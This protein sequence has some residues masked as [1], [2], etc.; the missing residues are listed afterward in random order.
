[1]KIDPAIMIFVFLIGSATSRRMH[2]LSDE[3]IDYINSEQTL[4]RAGRNFPRNTPLSYLK[5]LSGTIKEDTRYGNSFAGTPPRYKHIDKCNL[6]IIFDARVEWENCP[7]LWD[8]RDQGACGS[9]WAV[10]AASAMSDRLCIGS[11]GRKKVYLSEIDVI[12][13]CMYCGSSCQGGVLSKAWQFA[14]NKGIVSGGKYDSGKGCRP[15]TIPPCVHIMTNFYSPPIC[16]HDDDHFNTICTETCQRNHKISYRKD[17]VKLRYFYKMT[18]ETQIMTDIYM[19]GPVTT[20]F[21]LCEDFFN[22]KYGV[23]KY[24][25][26]KV[27]GLHSI[28]LLG[29][30]EERGVAYWL[31]A[32]SWNE[33]WGDKGFFKIIRGINHL[34]IESMAYAGVFSSY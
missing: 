27:L 21:Y 5:R 18:N 33:Y 26:G 11:K 28:K 24:T 20:S 15:Y 12:S 2:P 4:W 10:S 16:G 19:K 22:Y 31:A 8:I 34:G 13:C 7:S 17:K 9:C 29:W 23:Y 25:G 14:Q 1:M 32:N 6:P 30:G 3:L